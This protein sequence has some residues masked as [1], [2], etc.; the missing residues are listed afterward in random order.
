[1]VCQDIADLP[2]NR[3]MLD[4]IIIDF[5]KAFDLV[6]HNQLFANIAAS[7]VEFNVGLWIREFLLGRVQRVRGKL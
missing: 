5:L 4:A 7:S 3:A 2:D 6:P 1:M